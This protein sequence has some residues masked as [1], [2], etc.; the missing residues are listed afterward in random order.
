[1][2]NKNNPIPPLWYAVVGR[3]I[4]LSIPIAFFGFCLYQKFLATNPIPAIV[5]FVDFV[6]VFLAIMCVT[7]SGAIAVGILF[8]ITEL[9]KWLWSGFGKVK[10]VDSD[11]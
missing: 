4:V 6:F 3:S 10:N 11:F 7:F 8:G 9:I 1:M 5:G 2:I